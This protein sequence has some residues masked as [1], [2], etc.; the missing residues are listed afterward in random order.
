MPKTIRVHLDEHCSNA[1]AKGLRR[2]GVDVTT[3]N[4]AG[5]R[6]ALD[7]E[8]LR[9][10]ARE[11]RMLFTQDEDFLVLHSQGIPHFGITYCQ[12]GSRSLGEILRAL[13]LIWEVYELAEMENKLEYL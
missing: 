5:L 6:G 11:Q 2:R 13:I 3:A 12:P 4:D 9:F 7:S 8:H 10:A 1:L